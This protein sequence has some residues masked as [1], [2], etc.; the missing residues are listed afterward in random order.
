MPNQPSFYSSTPLT[1][2]AFIFSN[3]P[4]SPSLNH[5]HSSPSLTSQATDSVK[6]FQSSLEK[7]FSSGLF[8]GMCP[9]MRGGKGSR[10]QFQWPCAL[11]ISVAS[12]LQLVV[13][14]SRKAGFDTIGAFLFALF[15]ES[16]G[17]YTQHASLAQ[18]ISAFIRNGTQVAGIVNLLYQHTDA[19]SYHDR[20]SDEPHFTLP[21][22][23]LAPTL[24][25]QHVL[26][27]PLPNCTKNALINWALSVVL[28]R[29]DV[30]STWLA[31]CSTFVRKKNKQISWDLLLSWWMNGSQE[32][33]A[34]IA[35]ALFAIMSTCAV[36]KENCEQL[37]DVANNASDVL[38]GI[39]SGNERTSNATPTRTATFDTVSSGAPITMQSDPWLGVTVAI[40]ALLHLLYAY[41]IIFPTLV[42]VFLFTCNA[43]RDV[44]AMLSR[45][46][47]SVAYSTVLSSLHILASD[48]DTRLRTFGATLDSAAPTFQILFD[49][50]N[51]MRCAWQQSLG[52]RDEVKSGMVATLVQL[53]DVLPGALKAEPLLR[54]IAK[55]ERKNLTVMA[56]R[57]DVDWGNLRGIGGATVLHVW[58]KH[59]L[60]LARFQPDVERLFSSSYAKQPLW[61]RKSQVFSMQSTNIDESMTHGTK[62][63]LYNLV[64]AQLGIAVAWMVRWLI[65]VCGDQLTIDQICTIKRYMSKVQPGFEWHDWALPII[66][67]WHLKWNWQKAIFHLHWFPLD[68]NKL[69][70]LHQETVEIMERTKFNHDKCNFYPAHHILEDHFEAMILEALRLIC[71][72]KTGKSYPINMPLLDALQGFFGPEGV[73]H[74]CNFEMVVDYSSLVYKRYMC[75]WAYDAAV[76]AYRP[77]ETFGPPAS[78]SASN[79][80]GVSQKFPTTKKPRRRTGNNK[81]APVKTRN[82]VNGDQCL[83]NNIGFL[84]CT[85]WYLKLCASIAEG[86]IGHAFEIIKL[87]RF[88]FWG[89]GS[90]NY[91]NELLELACNFLYEFPEGL[92]ETILNNYLVNTS[93]HPGHWFELDLMQEHFNFWFKR[94]FNSKSHEFDSKHLAEAVGLNIQGFSQLQD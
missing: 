59:V 89:A 22:Y 51:K 18:C 93:G 50:V 17:K 82:L 34:N 70:G 24:R 8:N 10:S 6:D 45:I 12:R 80:E 58:L 19:I 77:A 27:P 73:L 49:N 28:D 39:P 63:V 44:I 40:L 60:A 62:N 65:C 11:D 71:E 3:I 88:S 72:E 7:Q 86:D 43:H 76:H 74:Q 48:A 47:I 35:P 33:I 83:A 31:E 84:Q 9:T 4:P 64:T 92:V 36:S 21:W 57:Q 30:E 52:C 2:P 61:L 5:Y 15:T 41:A 38:P 68:G 85:F 66:Q 14:A 78:L 54:N 67:L 23:A 91:G 56:L 1:P 94:L 29:V 53:E 46:G 20:K 69:Y 81:A 75:S 79:V 90:M 16:E 32:K 37:K 55:Q 87:L 26:P 13:N 42:G 25:L